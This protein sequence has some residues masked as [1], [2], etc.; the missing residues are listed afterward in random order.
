MWCVCFLLC[1]RGF[2][3][4]GT[5]VY[6]RFPSSSVARIIVASLITL[7]WCFVSIFSAADVIYD[8]VD[9][10]ANI[11]FGA[12]VDDKITNGEVRYFCLH[13]LFLS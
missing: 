3:L 12:L 13:F 6:S 8:N 11:I 9:E 1:C 2:E 10:D 4:C 7:I 5:L